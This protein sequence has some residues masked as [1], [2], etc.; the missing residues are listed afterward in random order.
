MVSNLNKVSVFISSKCDNEDDIQSGRIKYSVTRKALKLL[1][2]ESGMCNVYAF[3][4]GTATSFN[5][6]NSYMDKLDDADLVIV[7]VDNKDGI[8][9]ATMKEIGRVKA[10][11]KKCI[12]F[13][14]DEREKNITELQNELQSSTK[15]SRFYVVHEFADLAK[16]AYDAVVNDIMTIYISYCKGRVDYQEEQNES[17]EN[18]VN[19][20]L[21]TAQ[22]I[23]IHKKLFSEFIFSKYIVQKEAGVSFGDVECKNPADD[24]CSSLLG[25]VIGSSQTKNS[26]FTKIKYDTKS[27]HKG[28]VQKLIIIRFE[29]VEQYFHGNINLCIEKLKECIAFCKSCKN[30]PKWLYNDIA[31][32][33]RNIQIERDREDDVINFKTEGQKILDDDQEPLYYPIIDRTVSDYRECIVKNY[34]KNVNKSTYTVNIGGIDNTLDKVVDAFIVAYYYGSITHMIMTRQRLY[35]YLIGVSLDIRSHKM[36]MFCVELLL[37]ANDEKNLKMFLNNYGENTNNI[38]AKDVEH[39]LRAIEK[40]PVKT[41]YIMSKQLA[42]KYFGYY[43]SDE[44]FS[45]ESIQI[46]EIMDEC[47]VNKYSTSI[48]IKTMF[49]VFS[50]NAYRWEEEQVLEFVLVIF[51]KQLKRYYDDAYRFIY[52]F[53][54]KTLSIESQEKLQELIIN[55][56][57]DDEIRKQCH[58]LGIAAQ[59]VRQQETISHEELDTS[60]EKYLKE[61]YRDTYILNTQN[62]S[63]EKGWEYVKKYTDVIKADNE[64]QAKNGV[65]SR[66]AYNPYRT[67]GNIIVKDEIE[68]R[69]EQLKYI[70][71]SLKDTLLSN[72][73]TVD[74]KCDALELICILQLLKP[75]NKRIKKIVMDIEPKW[76]E[77]K[78]AMDDSLVHEHSEENLDFIFCMLKSVLGIQ[79]E[80]DINISLMH[81]QNSN[82]PEQI[83]ALRC[84]E[85]LASYGILKYF[86]INEKNILFQYVF[87]ATYNANY[88]VRFYAMSA[89]VKIMNYTERQLCL[90]RFVEMMD[91]EPYKGKVGLLYRLRDEDISDPKVR[92]ILDKGV[93]DSHFWVKKVAG[94]IL[95]SKTY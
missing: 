79:R 2:E 42:L 1:L 38:N 12:Y 80:L 29:A 49:D 88:D 30:I 45:K 69:S 33:L 28:N 93:N 31:L 15:N 3:E 44:T 92:F 58:N 20:E 64:N 25:W 17:D 91:N 77:I 62:H 66:K 55:S 51:E 9:S 76:H 87:S 46:L 90:E 94:D 34:L 52:N 4:E 6:V 43:Y 19:I 61:F 48:L 40:Q 67:I 13:F 36:F 32:D 5:V 82:I 23:L 39:M 70:L 56:L 37:L 50:D 26:D 24:N 8:T 10:L 57:R 75:R 81:I 7:L 41:R 35:E 73:Q 54:F 68:L 16:Y 18:T 72:T 65:Y 11:G 83:S 63:A 78:V 14:C 53:K 71:E 86:N 47:I 85:R 27:I 59:N 74:A 95:K 21:S 84:V 60:V 22:D 89:L